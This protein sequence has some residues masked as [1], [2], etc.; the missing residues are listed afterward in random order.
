MSSIVQNDT[1]AIVIYMVLSDHVTPATG[2][3]VTMNLSKAGAAFA[4]GGGTVTELAN[5]FYKYTPVAADVGTL[6]DL[7][8]RATAS[9]C[10]DWTDVRRVVQAGPLAADYTTARAAKLDTADAAS[11][12]SAVIETNGGTT[13]TVKQAL[14]LAAALPAGTVANIL[15]GAGNQTITVTSASGQP[16]L[17]IAGDELGN[18]VV[19]RSPIT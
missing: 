10:D 11:F 16:F 6:G 1:S 12:L 9:G 15:A 19:T 14:Q 13:I 2:K 5:G 8:F 18:R 3:T 17:S 7:A 4:A